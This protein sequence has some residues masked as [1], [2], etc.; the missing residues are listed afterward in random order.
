MTREVIGLVVLDLIFVIV[1]QAMLAGLGVIRSSAECGRFLGLALV[2][3]WAVTGCSLSI[4]L[5]LGA[6]FRWYVAAAAWGSTLAVSA[7]GLSRCRR[8]SW[9][10]LLEERP[11]GRWAARCAA[12]LLVLYVLLLVV[13]SARFDGGFHP[14]VWSFWLPKAKIIYLFHGLAAGDGGMTSQGSPDYP[15]FDPILDALS[16]GAM[17]RADVLLLPVQHVVIAAG[18]LG[19][20]A[21]LLGR[22]V[23]PALLYP[24]LAALALMPGWSRLAGSCLADESLALCLATAALLGALWLLEPR[25]W[26]LALCSL[27][28]VAA[29][30]DKNEGLM[31]GVSLVVGLA[32]ASR[33]IT[34]ILALLSPVVVAVVVWRIWLHAHHVPPNA[35]YD[36]SHVLHPGYLADHLSRLGYGSRKLLSD[37]AAPR[38]WLALTPLALVAAWSAGRAGARVSTL[39][40]GTLLLGLSGF[41]VIYWTSP[42]ELHYYVDN[43]VSRVVSSLALVAA[44]LFPLLLAQAGALDRLLGSAGDGGSRAL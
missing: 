21:A 11:I 35:A 42:L 36:L 43:S 4:V 44:V 19:S 17:G 14:D 27:F 32:V 18:F 8:S 5:A 25:S 20:A 6:P 29:A 3:G 30:L 37:L 12:A 41:A 13:R 34:A 24:S 26:L 10:P 28:L 23:R 31:L 40:L 39:L 33:R 2:C 7:A 9:A 16:F 15:P 22:K 38:E 1:G